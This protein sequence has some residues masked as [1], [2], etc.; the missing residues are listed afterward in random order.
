VAS[1]DDIAAF[2]D[3]A[4]DAAGY[5]D[6]LPVGLQVLGAAEVSRIASGVS[7]SRE[8]FQR[9]G[10]AGAQMLVVHHGLFW[11]REPR[12]IGRLERER[13][14]AL[15]DAD[16]SLL[17]YH[18]C[19]DAHPT[20][21][22]NAIL[23]DLLGVAERE[24]FGEHHGRTIAFAG[25]LEPAVT[26]DELLAR[27]RERVSSEMLVFADG[28]PRI[29]R[30]AVV[31]GGAAGDIRAA[32]E[33]GAHAFV[34]GEAAEPT[35]HLARELGVHYIAAGHYATEVF[36]VRAV[37]DLVASQFGIEHEFIDLPN[38]V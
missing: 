1:R 28:P 4:L 10:E 25:R 37:G 12:R 18:L 9:A 20:L 15:F 3:E 13:L 30:V 22:N 8:L 19:L 34:T 35:L 6:A 29:E 26:L 31:S 11:D 5:P 36:G 16:L 17:A 21:G 23:C 38:P 7:A 32:A 14:R 33:A 24:P 27:L 2:L